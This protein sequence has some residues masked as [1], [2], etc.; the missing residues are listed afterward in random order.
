MRYRETLEK[1]ETAYNQ[2]A[3]S[4]PDIKKGTNVAVQN[5]VTKISDIYGIVTDINPHHRY[6]IR[7]Q[8]GSILVRN[9]R[10]LRHRTPV[11]VHG[12]TPGDLSVQPSSTQQETTLRR[13][14]RTCHRPKRLIEEI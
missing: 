1:A 10:F 7:T 8:S 14:S 12:Y 2:R 13:S 5:P 4:L 3:Q 9:R 11:S 6:F